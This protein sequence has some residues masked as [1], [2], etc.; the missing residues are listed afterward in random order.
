MGLFRSHDSSR[1]FDKLTQ[2]AF[3]GLFLIEFTT[4]NSLNS[5]GFT[6]GIFLSI[7]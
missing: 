1:E 6:N 3:L 7:I 4:R 5:N 2:V